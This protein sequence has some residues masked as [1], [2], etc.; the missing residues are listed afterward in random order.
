MRYDFQI[1]FI[2]LYYTY[3]LLQYIMK[4]YKRNNSFDHLQA[5]FAFQI[6]V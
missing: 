2:T 6:T 3:N 4:K 5:Q 1:T